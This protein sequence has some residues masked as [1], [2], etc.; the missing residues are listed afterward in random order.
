MTLFIKL[1]T[2]AI[3]KSPF[4]PLCQMGKLHNE[5]NFPSLEKHALSRVEGRG[6]GRFW[7]RV[8]G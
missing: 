6:Q 4:V 3:K 7:T 2:S 5:N 8:I 1:T